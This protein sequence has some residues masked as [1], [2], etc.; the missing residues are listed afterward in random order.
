MD[1]NEVAHLIGINK[2]LNCSSLECLVTVWDNVFAEWVE[3]VG[4]RGLLGLHTVV[5]SS[6]LVLL[7]IFRWHGVEVVCIA[8]LLVPALE[9]QSEL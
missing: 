4:N 9:I 1:K 3:M 7:G 2:P 6:L 5:Q 8:P